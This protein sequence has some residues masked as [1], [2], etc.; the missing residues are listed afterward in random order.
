MSFCPGLS[1]FVSLL[2]HFSKDHLKSIEI[3]KD[4]YRL[5]LLVGKR[6]AIM[7]YIAGKKNMSL[8]LM[9]KI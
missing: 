8:L 5:L 7:N 1:L 6:S 9:K 2:A 3:N 4:L